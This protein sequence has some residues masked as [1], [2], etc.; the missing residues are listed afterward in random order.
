MKKSVLLALLVGFF[1]IG[2]SQPKIKNLAYPDSVKLFG[3]YE[4]SFQ[5]GNYDNP[6][7]PDIIDVFAEMTDPDGHIHRVNGF[8]YE[9]YEFSNV[10]KMEKAVPNPSKNGWRVRFTPCQT[11]KWTFALHAK[12][13]TGETILHSIDSKT[14]SFICQAV[15]N[16]K[17]FIT[18]ANSKYL[19]Q[20]VVRNGQRGYSSF[21]PIGPN[22]AW[23]ACASY[24][25]Y[26]T[27]MGIY[28]YQRYMDSLRGNANYM[29]IWLT[30][31]QSLSLYGPEYTQVVN[32][33]PVVYFNNT[34]NQK[35]AAELDHIIQ[36]AAAN[37]IA[38]MPC[39]FTYGDWKATTQTLE[40]HPSDWR[41]NPFNTLFRRPSDIFIDARAKKIM[42]NHLRYIAARWGY[43]PNIV[44]WELWNEVSNMEH[45]DIPDDQFQT[46]ILKWHE[47]MAPYL[48][49]QDSHHHLVTTSMGG[50]NGL[51]KLDKN[52]YNNLDFSQLHNY[53]NIHKAVS[54]SQFSYVLY[55]IAKEKHEQFPAIP[56]FVGEFGFGQSSSQKKYSDHDPLGIDLHNSLWSSLFSGTMGTASFWYWDVLKSCGLFARTK[57]MLNFA[58]SLPLLSDSFTAQHTGYISKNTLVFPNNLETYY[59]INSTEDTVYGWS[60]DTAFC[61]QSLRHLTNKTIVK[62]HFEPG[63]VTDSKGYVYTLDSDKKPEPSSRDNTLEIPIHNQPVG[64]Q[65][66]V[67][68]YD[69]ETGYEMGKERTTATVTADR[70]GNKQLT[71]QFPS[72]IRDVKNRRINNTFGD[73][74]FGITKKAPDAPTTTITTEKDVPSVNKVPTPNETPAVNKVPAT[75]ETPAK[76]VVPAKPKKN[77]SDT[78]NATPKSIKIKPN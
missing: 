42:R 15:D 49:S 22:V 66:I 31:F 61:Y 75:T 13:K 40:E 58:K 25:D 60:Q 10:N 4:I 73:A 63:G 71:F 1:T 44:A 54:K 16:A 21:F 33:K 26:S 78:K 74:V 28:D 48:R 67:R 45:G 46:N 6:Y 59:L 18:K 32:G 62:N 12:D 35:D 77:G 43:A 55:D 50:S 37:D 17:G 76:K 64:T 70:R 47:E 8:Y 56:V 29:R 69:T 30:R 57:P 68:W 38:V 11:G 65:Y 23:Y 3:L 53:Q 24:F 27:P 9:D 51:E 72:S 5:L 39:I 20:E 19:K 14:P 41:N 36:M 34:L 2:Y 52:L 7:D